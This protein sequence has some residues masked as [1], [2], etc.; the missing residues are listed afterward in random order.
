MKVTARIL[1]CAGFLLALS[2]CGGRPQIVS[3]NAAMERNVALGLLLE[4]DSNQDQLLS[5]AEFETALQAN[6]SDLDRNKDGSLDS[7]EV[8][9]ENDRRWRISGSSSTPLID[10]NTDGF[11]DFAEFT[12]TL[13]ST[14]TQM[15]ED[16]DGNLSA[17]E[18]AIIET[19]RPRLRGTSGPP[20]GQPEQYPNGYPVG[21]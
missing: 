20:G 21:G 5:G 14:F 11:V 8:S 18:L 1:V 12:S 3:P 4:Y 15:D 19:S 17:E 9:A 16:D 2:A 7:L 10:W 6:F 13:Q